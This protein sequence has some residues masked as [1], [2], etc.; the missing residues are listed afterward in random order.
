MLGSARTTG[1]VSGL[2]VDVAYMDMD[3]DL[4]LLPGQIE[5]SDW[6]ACLNDAQH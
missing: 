2:Q 3:G 1:F 4:G 5:W 6:A